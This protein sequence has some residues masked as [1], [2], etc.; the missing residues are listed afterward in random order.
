MVVGGLAKR[1][2]FAGS[3]FQ[4]PNANL[5]S[6]IPTDWQRH[7]TWSYDADDGFGC[8]NIKEFED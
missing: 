7:M 5:R 1:F 4:T 2:I 6:V 3:G 8:Y